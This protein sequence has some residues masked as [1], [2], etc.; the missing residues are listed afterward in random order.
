MKLTYRS[1][2]NLLRHTNII[3]CTSR[4]DFKGR[5]Y[6][7]EEGKIHEIKYEFKCKKCNSKF[8]ANLPTKSR[9]ITCP[10]CKHTISKGEENLYKWLKSEYTGKIIQRSRT[11]IKPY[12]LDI[13]LP[14]LNI[15][16]EFNGVYWHKIRELENPGHHKNKAKLC[17]E[18]NIKLVNISDI[19]WE[20]K[21]SKCEEKLLEIINER[22]AAGKN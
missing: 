17:K 8:I 13:F 19:E 1:I 7:D 18:N 21:R 9:G 22:Q 20:K 6:A 5:T 16:I 14:E 10:L 12:E 3:F 11:I 2:K 4:K 15:G